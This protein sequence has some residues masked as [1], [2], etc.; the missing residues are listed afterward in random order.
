MNNNEKDLPWL[1]HQLKK[2]RYFLE[3]M[4]IRMKTNS[5]KKNIDQ[6]EKER[7]EAEEETVGDGIRAEGPDPQ[8][9]G[10]TRSPKQQKKG[11]VRPAKRKN[12]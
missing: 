2:K 11:P 6:R 4:N 5:L 12:Q 7:K 3:K 1:H 9:R 10:L 8:E